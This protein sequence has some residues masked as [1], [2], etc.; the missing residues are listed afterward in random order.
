LQFDP[1]GF[2]TS[3]GFVFWSLNMSGEVES[4]QPE[5]IEDSADQSDADFDAGFEQ[6]EGQ[7]TT[8]ESQASQASEEVETPEE[9]EP[10]YAKIT[11]AQFQDLLAR[12]ASIDTIRADATKRFDTAFGQLGGLKQTVER[13]QQGSGKAIEVTGDDFTELKSEFPELADLQIQGLN[14]VLSKLGGGGLGSDAVTKMASEVAEAR[15]DALDGLN[16][17][18]PD[19]ELAVKT[20]E[21]SDWL[22]KA[23]DTVK[24]LS[25][26]D[27]VRDA[28]AL[29][30]QFRDRPKTVTPP[31]PQPSTR[32]RQLEAAVVPRGSRGAAPESREDD[33][34]EAGFNGRN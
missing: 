11:E 23:N 19:W 13:L 9:S 25:A 1:P 6:A 21:F 3:A 32:Q 17:I 2:A 7:T 34:F 30:R 5:G 33:D 29:L 22:G 12:A 14:R 24:A 8:P 18:I 31:K 4:G 16:N 27:K 20:P 15:A 28:A 26:S 10:T